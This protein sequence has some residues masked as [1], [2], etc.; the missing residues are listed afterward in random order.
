M[1]AVPVGA[2]G[3]ED[4]EADVQLLR[5][6]EGDAAAHVTAGLRLP[7]VPLPGRHNEPGAVG[8]SRDRQ[9]CVLL[10]FARSFQVDTLDGRGIA[11]GNEYL[12]LMLPLA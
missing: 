7:D 2:R 9:S 11:F 12:E 6:K 4:G 1:F 10:Q 8:D 3:D 5:I